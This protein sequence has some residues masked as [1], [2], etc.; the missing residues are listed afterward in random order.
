[1]H[2][3]PALLPAPI[4]DGVLNRFDADRVVIH[5]QGTRGFARCWAN[6]AGEL[7]EIVGAVQNRQSVLPVVVEHQIVEVR[8]DV[9]DRTTA[10]AKRCTAIHATR[11][12]RFGLL[13]AQADDEFFVMFEPLRHGLVALFDALK[14]HEAGDFSHDSVP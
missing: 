11:A 1:M 13:G 12:L 5:I 6:A 10:V 9:V 2:F 7:G 14:L 3:D 8:N 4:D